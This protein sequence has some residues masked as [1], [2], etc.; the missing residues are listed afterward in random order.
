LKIV[1][2]VRERRSTDSLNKRWEKITG[3]KLEVLWESMK[4]FENVV[5]LNKKNNNLEEIKEEGEVAV[6]MPFDFKDVND[7]ELEGE[8]LSMLVI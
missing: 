2:D 7:N 3:A 4:G 6:V 1:D 8:D 5:E